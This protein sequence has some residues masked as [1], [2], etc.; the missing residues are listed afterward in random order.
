MDSVET[1]EY[2]EQLAKVKRMK[3]KLRDQ[4]NSEDNPYDENDYTKI[5]RADLEF[6]PKVGQTFLSYSENVQIYANANSKKNIQTHINGP[7]GAWYTHRNPAG[8]FACEDTNLISVLV[9]V[10][11][12]MASIHPIDTFKTTES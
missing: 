10:I 11:Q 1:R 5:L 2:E 3:L 12:Y 7:K 6:T 8:C 9:Q 4:Y